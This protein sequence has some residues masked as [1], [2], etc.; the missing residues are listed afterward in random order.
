[1]YHVYFDSE[2]Q[3]VECFTE[4]QNNNQCVHKGGCKA[5]PFYLD[6]RCRS[7]YI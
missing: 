5:C 1:M 3:L 6:P 4:K 7:T 2:K